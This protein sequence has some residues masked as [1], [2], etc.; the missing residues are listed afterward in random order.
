MLLT[1]LLRQPLRAFAE[2]YGPQ[3][4][5]RGLRALIP[6]GKQGLLAFVIAAGL[7]LVIDLCFIESVLVPSDSM[8]PA[9]LPNERVLLRHWPRPAVR[10]FDVVAIAS[11]VL[12]KRIAKRVVALPGEIVRLEDSWRVVIDGQALDYSEES[13]EGRR[14][15]ARHH[16][17]QLAGA[18]AVE[19]RF[20]SQD[21]LLG[22]DEYFVLGDNRLTS[23]D[24]RVIGPVKRREI[25]GTLTTVWYSFDPDLHRI[26]AQRLLCKIR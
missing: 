20:G 26:R 12:H 15:E 21:L 5:R 2:W 16:A 25:E 1:S 3:P 22:P 7:L 8:R 17:I 10:R 19:T 6:T 4:P 23:D 24:S 14:V 9:V 18:P 13:V 11:T